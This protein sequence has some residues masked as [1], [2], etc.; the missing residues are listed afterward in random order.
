MCC[1]HHGP[2]TRY[3]FNFAQGEP[4]LENLEFYTCQMHVSSSRPPRQN[5][6]AKHYLELHVDNNTLNKMAELMTL[7]GGSGETSS[8]ATR[9]SRA[10]PSLALNEPDAPAILNLASRASELRAG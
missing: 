8:S 2:H 10:I 4:K 1:S 5:R 6:R 3:M 7:R 9:S